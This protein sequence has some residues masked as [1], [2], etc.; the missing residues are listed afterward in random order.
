MVTADD[1]NGPDQDASG[2]TIY[3]DA[4][5]GGDPGFIFRFDPVS[6]G[7]DVNPFPYVGWLGL[8]LNGL[9]TQDDQLGR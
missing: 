2:Q 9:V 6:P 4:E 8:D 5:L 1:L 7:I 3:V